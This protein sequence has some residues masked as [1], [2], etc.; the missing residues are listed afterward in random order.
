MRLLLHSCLTYYDADARPAGDSYV[1]CLFVDKRIL[2][3]KYT[4]YG[5]AYFSTY[6]SYKVT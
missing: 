2:P 6:W 4:L 3:N 1:F 5:K